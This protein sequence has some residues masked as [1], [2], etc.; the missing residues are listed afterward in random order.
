MSSA[1]FGTFMQTEMKKWGEVV[2]KGG[3]K[4]Q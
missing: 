4:A 1:E 2:H 3:I